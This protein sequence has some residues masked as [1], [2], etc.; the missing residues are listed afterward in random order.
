MNFKKEIKNRPIT[1]MIE[2]ATGDPQKIRVIVKDD[3]KPFTVY[4]DRYA[5]VNGK[6]KYF[7]RMPLSPYIAKISVYNDANGDL[8][9][10]QDPTFKVIEFKEL[11]LKRKLGCIDFKNP[12]IKSFIA[13][14]EQ[15]CQK[16]GYISAGGSVYMSEDGKFRIDYLD[17]I[18]AKSGK[19]L[20]TPARI[21]QT[22]GNI[23]VSKDFFKKYTV[24]MRMAILLHEFS[25]YYLNNKMEDEVEADLNGL[26][27]YLG[28]GFPRIE[29]FQSF[30]TVF[31]ETP[32]EQNKGRFDVL[33]QFVSNFEK[34]RYNISY[35]G[36]YLRASSGKCEVN[37]N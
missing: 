1:L 8:K 19:K 14:A 22:R 5:T 37:T 2:V 12:E 31:Q 18:K 34:G 16:A 9:K 25:H 6:L 17:T 20:T 21:S 29:A 30:L 27:L 15:F 32:T 7:V 33:N 4:T 24:P 28:L 13:F 3:D 23:Q 26:L 10:G 11:P 35:S 36:Q